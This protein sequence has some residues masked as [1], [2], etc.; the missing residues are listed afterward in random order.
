MMPS[1]KEVRRLCLGLVAS[2]VLVLACAEEEP[3]R[4]TKKAAE[5]PA[6]KADDDDDEKEEEITPEPEPEPDPEPELEE[7]S[8]DAPS[9]AG[10]APGVPE[11]K[12]G[13]LP[14]AKKTEF[15]ASFDACA[16]ANTSW[17]AVTGTNGAPSCGGALVPWCCT[18]EQITKRF[19]ETAAALET[20]FKTFVDEAGLRLYHCS[21][22]PEGKTRFHFVRFDQQAVYRT[23]VTKEAP[24][25]GVEDATDCQKPTFEG[26]F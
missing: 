4:E 17:V 9:P 26:L 11:P 2:L 13:S 12:P 1:L 18:R 5:K 23:T 14:D 3:P 8:G 6:P 16:N 25:A 21:V 19:P 20:R 22:D 15:K 7:S 24:A 10:P